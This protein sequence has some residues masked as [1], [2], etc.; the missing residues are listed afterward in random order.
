MMIVNNFTFNR[1]VVPTDREIILPISNDFDYYGINEAYQEFEDSVLSQLLRSDDDFEVNRFCHGENPN[2]TTSIDYEFNFFSGGTSVTATTSSDSNLWVNTYQTYFTAYNIYNVSPAFDKSFFK[3]D[4]YDSPSTTDQKLYFS[5]IIPTQQGE[6]QS[7][8]LFNSKTLDIR[9]PY[10]SLDYIGDKEGFFLYWLKKRL[11]V[12][13]DTF[14]VSAKFYNADIGQFIRFMNTPQS[15]IPG[16]V[17]FNFD[18][19]NYFY[20]KYVLNY[21]DQTYKAYGYPVE[22]E[23]GSSSSPIKWY[24]YINP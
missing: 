2:G 12:N 5:V 21:D 14:Y 9:K 4:F 20:Y 17:K 13:V 8:I 3:L 18:S 11:Y 15:N 6:T 1:N 10:F 19:T 22:N 24:E 16:P 23:V 7:A